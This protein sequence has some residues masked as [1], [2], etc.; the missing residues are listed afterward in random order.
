MRRNTFGRV[1]AG[2]LAVLAL[3]LV[4]TQPASATV[5]FTSGKVYVQQ[6]VYDKAAYFLECARKAEPENVDALSLLAFARAQQR[7]FLSAGAAFQLALDIARKK[8]D[9]KKIAD[10]ER[11][12]LAV[13][14]QLFNA[15]VKALS[16]SKTAEAPTESALPAYK[17]APPAQEAVTDTTVF[18]PFT[19]ASRLEE[20]GYDFILA[21]YVDPGSVETYQNLAY[22]MG[23]LGRTD[24]AIRA[25]SKGLEVK[26]DDQR[27]KTNLRAAVMGRAV[28]LY[29]DGKYAEAIDAFRD[30][31]KKDPDPQSQPGYQVRIAASYY[32]I[33]KAAT[34]DSPQQTAAYD[35]A[36]VGYS[37]VLDEAAA[38]DSLKQNAL[39]N[40][41][42]IK[43]NQGKT[44]EAIALLD[45]G[46]GLYPNNK[47][48]WS[49]NG[50]LKNT[51]QDFK[52]AVTALQHAMELDP[53]DPADHQAMF[54]ALNKTGDREKSVAEY[55]IYKA[56]GGTKKSN[57]QIWVDAV[58]N[59]Y[60]PQNSLKKV[61]AD[62]GY[63][64]EV[65]TYTEE[66]KRFETWFFWSKGKSYTFMEGQTFSKG[67]FPPKKS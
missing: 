1:S 66:N 15:G 17:P 13:N 48:M 34:A 26:P 59:R 23:G 54:L 30:A 36:A 27:L 37:A 35:S 38:S 43:A 33:G 61:K 31:K 49:L 46:N 60:G 52:G 11:N 3:G 58:D 29:N 44:K 19:G 32:E 25:A 47:D 62:E 24:D 12:R 65:Y 67:A 10:L 9:T 42:V 8:N 14:A 6:K 2:V 28:G 57:L 20:A 16:G 50:Q 4:Q 53:Q 45:K 18:P 64:E 5:C 63:P 55:S 40:A 41:A 21:S 51:A 22:V 56:L 39:Y 7:Q